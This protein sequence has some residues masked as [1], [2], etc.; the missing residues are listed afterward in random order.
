MYFAVHMSYR[1][2]YYYDI[3]LCRDII[4]GNFHT[5]AVNSSSGFE[6][7]DKYL[8]KNLAIPCANKPS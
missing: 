8:K 4:L 3:M 2:Y 6:C 5:T 7:F 1:I